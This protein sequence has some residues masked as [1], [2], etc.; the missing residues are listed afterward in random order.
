M[1]CRAVES[2]PSC[3]SFTL[4]IWQIFATARMKWIHSEIIRRLC[5]SLPRIGWK[6]RCD[7]TA[8]CSRPGCQL[9]F[10]MAVAD[11]C[12]CSVWT[13]GRSSIDSSYCINGF[14]LSCGTQCRDLGVTITSDLSSSQHI[15]EITAE[16]HERANCILRCF[17]YRDV[18][19][20]VRAFT[21]YVRP[22]LEYNSVIWS[23]YLKKKSLKSRKSRGVSQRGCVGSVMLDILNN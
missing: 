12:K 19:L 7:K 16:A 5:K 21:V 17:A 6:R 9:G 15:N 22:I 20:L 14:S 18:K 8:R 4:T 10:T 1:W 11:I 3:F 2:G 23:P 13:V